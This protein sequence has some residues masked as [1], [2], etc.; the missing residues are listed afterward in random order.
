MR[1]ALRLSV[2]VSIFA[3]MLFSYGCKSGEIDDPAVK[4]FRPS[5]ERLISYQASFD[6]QLEQLQQKEIELDSIMVTLEEKHAVMIERENNLN[7]MHED[8]TALQAK[9][10]SR[11]TNAKMLMNTGYSLMLIGLILLL[12][13]LVIL[14]KLNKSLYMSRNSD[15][16]EDEDED[17]IEDEIE[18]K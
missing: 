13:S 10:Q 2:L 6:R 18:D 5:D 14:R 16:D 15:E 4:T 12:I 11:E 1:K 8:L 17:E 9:L 3:V 7:K